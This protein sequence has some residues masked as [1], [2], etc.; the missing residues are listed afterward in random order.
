MHSY[1]LI[2]FW[3]ALGVETQK[4][5][6]L[7][8]MTD[9]HRFD[10]FSFLGNKALKTPHFDSL[11]SEGVH[12]E[13]AFSSTPTC[14]PARAGLLTGRSPWGHGMLGYGSIAHEYPYE[15]PVAL[16]NAGYATSTFGK[17]HFGWNKTINKGIAHGFQNLMLYD[18]LGNGFPSGSEYDDYDQWFQQVK[19]GKDPMAT[20]LDWNTWHGKAYVYEEKYHPTAWLGRQVESFIL[21]YNDSRPFFIKASFHRPHSPYDPPA[22]I[23]NKTLATDLPPIITGEI[24]DEMFRDPAK[25]GSE[26]D[27]WCG[28]MPADNVVM[29]R[30]SYHASISFVD[31]NIGLILKALKTKRF[32]ENTF[33]LFTAD[34]GDGQSDHW[35]WRKGYPYEFSAHV[36]MLVRWPESM[37]SQVKMKRGSTSS[38]V[39]ELRDI[40]PTFLSVA[41]IT[42]PP[43]M[44]D[45]QS[46]TCLLAD[47]GGKSCNWRQWLD[48]E[49]STCYNASNHW[50]AL[51]DGKMKYIFNAQFA[52]EQLF[53]LTSDPGER[54]ELSKNPN[55]KSELELWRGR[56]VAQFE[57][58]QRGVNWVQNGK[59]VARPKGQTYGP[60]YP[61]GPPPLVGSRLLLKSSSNQLAPA[62]EWQCN[63][64]GSVNGTIIS[65]MA[66]QSLCITYSASSLS[67]EPCSANSIPEQIFTYSKAEIKMQVVHKSTGLCIATQTSKVGSIVALE[68]CQSS[69]STQLWVYGSSGRFCQGPC[70]TASKYGIASFAWDPDYIAQP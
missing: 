32:W 61:K 45:G 51:T 20:G 44:V 41:G 21:N 11:A 57:R 1:L 15:M 58:E 34:H 55:Y 22:R 37:E 53:N 46:L 62:Q 31:E 52:T 48:L 18:G 70:I 13:W 40:L 26:V 59:L 9:Q 35:H 28:E 60:N 49:H 24:W 12:M 30:R 27:A 5:N 6:I 8:L 47:P 69:A 16:A 33:I 4:S 39:V 68:K 25:C 38:F 67:L 7:L 3:Y 42:P 56:M 66:N 54:A 65:L 10:M 50:N 2:L 63:R 64:S 17:D 14:T 43:R 19:P 29:S 36:P 23:L